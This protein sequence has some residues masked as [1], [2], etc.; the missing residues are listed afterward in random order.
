MDNKN[1]GAVK[2]N[3][4]APDVLFW[5]GHLCFLS[6]EKLLIKKPHM[7]FT[8]QRHRYSTP[9]IFTGAVFCNVKVKPD[10]NL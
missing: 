7:S 3:K 1:E 5:N 8:A 2:Y 6:P 10:Q 4:G 9:H